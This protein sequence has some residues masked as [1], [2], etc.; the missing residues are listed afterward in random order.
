[1]DP[2]DRAAP[3]QRFGQR[4][5]TVADDAVDALDACSSVATN[6]SATLLI[7]MSVS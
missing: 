2:F 6:R 4:I 7:A 3:P 1:M 5:Q